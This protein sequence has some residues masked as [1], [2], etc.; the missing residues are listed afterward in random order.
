MNNSKSQKIKLQN[1]IGYI[2]YFGAKYFGP[3][4]YTENE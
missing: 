1:L 4:I 3:I 2:L